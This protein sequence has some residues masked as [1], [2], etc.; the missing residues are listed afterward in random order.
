[1]GSRLPVISREQQGGIIQDDAECINATPAMARNVECRING[2]HGSG[3]GGDNQA[4]LQDLRQ[5]HRAL[6]KKDEQWKQLMG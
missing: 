4:M 2:K 1:M 3:T 6:T 5:G